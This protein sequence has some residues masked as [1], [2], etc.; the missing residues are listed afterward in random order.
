MT[1]AGAPM[2]PYVRL[3]EGELQT[4]RNANARLREE[5]AGLHAVLEARPRA[6]WSRSPSGRKRCAAGTW[7]LLIC[8]RGC[9]LAPAA[10]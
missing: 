2:D 8:A 10:G 6:P 4:L 5:I 9:W 3:I 7:K 1:L